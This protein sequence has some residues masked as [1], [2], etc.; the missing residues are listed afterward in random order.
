[1]YK[2]NAAKSEFREGFDRG[3]TSWTRAIADPDLVNFAVAQPSEFSESGLDAWWAQL[4]NLFDF[5]AKLVMIVIGLSARKPGLVRIPYLHSIFESL[6]E[7]RRR[8]ADSLPFYADI[9][10][11]TVGDLDEGDAFV[12]PVVL[13]IEGHR[14]L[15]ASGG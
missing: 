6:L 8:S 13:A 7:N 12:H 3:D 1:L 2:I 14:A 5:T 15:N 4:Q 9:Y 10:F 11:D